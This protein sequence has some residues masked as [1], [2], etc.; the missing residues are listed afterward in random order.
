MS[1]INLDANSFN[2]LMAASSQAMG[3]LATESQKVNGTYRKGRL[4]IQGLNVVI[5]QPRHTYRTGTDKGT[6]KKWACILDADYGYFDA[7][8]G[9]DNEQLDCFVGVFPESNC[10]YVINQKNESGGF[11]EHKVMLG[12]LDYEHA[13]QTYENSYTIGW[14]GFVSMI[15]CTMAQFKWWLKFGDHTKPITS[16]SLPFDTESENINM[17][18]LIFNWAEGEKATAAR[19]IYA[20]DKTDPY[21]EVLESVDM[22]S[23]MDDVAE[24]GGE[25]VSDE[26]KFVT[27]PDDDKVVMDALVIKNA[28]LERKA[29]IIG[30]A[31]NRA[32]SGVKVAENG[33]QISKPFTLQRTT[34][35]VMIFEMTDGQTISAFL[36]NPDVKPKQITSEDNLI[37]WR[38]L[39]NRK[40]ITI[41]VAKE[42]GKD[43]RIPIV[44]SRIMALI[45]KNSDRFQ[46]A[47]EKKSE[48]IANINQLENS[49]AEKQATL[50]GIVDQIEQ[51]KS[52]KGAKNPSSKEPLKP[53]SDDN[54][55]IVEG[56]NSA[57]ELPAENET[58]N[59]TPEPEGENTPPKEPENTSPEENREG[60][61]ESESKEPEPPKEPEQ[62]TSLPTVTEPK[63]TGKPDQPDDNKRVN[64]L[65]AIID[66][67]DIAEFNF[68]VTSIDDDKL[69]DI[70]SEMDS[71]IAIADTEE[72]DLLDKAS[73]MIIDRTL[74][75]ANEVTK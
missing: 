43:L 35:R 29:N 67:K 18:D 21:E 68:G 69:L 62:G 52:G 49:I 24:E 27:N 39:L 15:P 34:Q 37:A 46:K 55:N 32:S 56:E 20:M 36:H 22:Q 54:T 28:Q 31:L 25:E 30:M 63:N 59:P 74:S 42:N 6:G 58:P 4:N 72:R 38:W 11:D 2:D 17:D 13:K 16:D 23:V 70:L 14:G 10:V 44:S 19:V 65:Q 45:N 60:T 64:F 61:K 71:Q 12:F 26:D 57:A 9:A 1:T 3:H 7:I 66:G 8:S 51:I 33:V 41:V 73:Q 40:D 75:S 50:Q 47:N 5:E 48:R 53:T